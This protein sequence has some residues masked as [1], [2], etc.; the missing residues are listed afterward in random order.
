V[1]GVEGLLA[2]MA[3][4]RQRSEAL[5]RRVEELEAENAALRAENAAL[6]KALEDERGAGKRSNSVIAPAR[7]NHMSIP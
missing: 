5:E 2:E 7:E 4:M 6:R 1:K 3:A